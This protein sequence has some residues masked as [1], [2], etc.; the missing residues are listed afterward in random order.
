MLGG[1]DEVCVDVI[2]V[3][4]WMLTVDLQILRG[5]DFGLRN[6]EFWMDVILVLVCRTDEAWMG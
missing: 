1:K 2:I 5:T 6:G 4:P 3:G